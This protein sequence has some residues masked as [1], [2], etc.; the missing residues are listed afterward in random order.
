VNH[1]THERRRRTR[2]GFVHFASFRAIRV[3]DRSR[4][5][6]SVHD[7]KSEHSR[8][9]SCFKKTRL[10]GGLPIDHRADWILC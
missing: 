10:D 4:K 5:Q 3:S 9:I 1:E 8:T 7:L 2:K 6:Y